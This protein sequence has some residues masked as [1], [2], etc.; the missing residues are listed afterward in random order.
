[1]NLVVWNIVDWRPICSSRIG[2]G[3]TF[4]KNFNKIVCDRV[5]SSKHQGTKLLI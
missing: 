4:F 1:M 2:N 3:I 5:K